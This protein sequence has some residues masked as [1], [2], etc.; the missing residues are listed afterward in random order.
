MQNYPKNIS[1]DAEFYSLQNGL[2]TSHSCSYKQP[3]HANTFSDLLLNL[4]SPISM[5]HPVSRLERSTTLKKQHLGKSN[6]FEHL[7]YL[8]LVN[9]KPCH[10]VTKSVTSLPFFL[11]F[12]I[13]MRVLER[14]PFSPFESRSKALQT[15]SFEVLY[16]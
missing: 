1:F 4:G 3:I 13:P 15:S 16:E 12:F 2:C 6:H 9:K 11:T 8:K 5:Y 10:S 7:K 14:K